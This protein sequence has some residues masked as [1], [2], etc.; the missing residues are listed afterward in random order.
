MT[1]G[2]GQQQFT[3]LSVSPYRVK[4]KYDYMYLIKYR[5]NSTF[6]ITCTDILQ[7]LSAWLFTDN[8]NKL[9]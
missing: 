8:N 1:A 4:V 6:M 3:G 7:L 2:E 9:Y 5:D